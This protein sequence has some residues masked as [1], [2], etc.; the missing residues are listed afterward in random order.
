[1]SS[2]LQDV[3]EEKVWTWEPTT[4]IFTSPASPQAKEEIVVRV[5]EVR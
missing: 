3:R 2:G 4:S 1:M 5:S